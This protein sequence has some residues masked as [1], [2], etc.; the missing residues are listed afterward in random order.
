MTKPAAISKPTIPYDGFPLYPHSSGQWAKRINGRVVYFGSWSAGWQAALEDFNAKRDYLY[1]GQ[2]PPNGD[3]TLLRDVLN[4]FRRSKVQSLEQGSLSQ[5]SLDEYEDVTD[6][7]A[8]VVG[9]L[10]PIETITTEDLARLRSALVKGKAGKII[11]PTSQRRI[12]TYARS[13][14]YHANEE[15]GC[16]IRYKKP[17]ASPSAKQLRKH[18]H[19]TGERLFAADEVRDLIAIAKPQLKAMILLGINCGFGNRDCA[20]LPIEQVD[21]ATGWHAYWRPKTQTPRRAPL[22]PETAAA[23]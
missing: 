7:I 5:R 16:S 4:S 17:L 9:K 19:E 3:A 22:W 20:T 11:S 13:V 12:L 6:V 15:C 21:L 10:R 1:A 14:F 18:R 2:A 23:L 8:S